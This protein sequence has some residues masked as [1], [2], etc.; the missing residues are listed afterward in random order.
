LNV[1]PLL[2]GVF[3]TKAARRIIDL[4]NT[5]QSA[6]ALGVITAPTGSGKTHAIRAW[7]REE[8]ALYF[9]M[10]GGAQL[11]VHAILYGLFAALKAM[12]RIG[13]HTNYNPVAAY[14]TVLDGLRRGHKSSI[15]SDEH[16]VLMLIVDE[17][18][19]LDYAGLTTL[20]DFAADGVPTVIAGDERLHNS[21]FGSKTSGKGQEWA[22]VRTRFRHR[23]LMKEKPDQADAA[24]VFAAHGVTDPEAFAALCSLAA[25]DGGLREASNVLEEARRRAPDQP[26]RYAMIRAVAMDMGLAQ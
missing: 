9:S 22:A 1:T 25:V 11:T 6:P 7:A 17:A 16:L 24:T 2:P 10:A 20:S 4:L 13:P 8:D 21:L 5:V 19:R 26:V 3:E 23:L 18:Q 14:S 12:D 15:I